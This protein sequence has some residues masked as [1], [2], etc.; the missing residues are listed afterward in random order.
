MFVKVHELN[1]RKVVAICDE[2]LIGK[3]FTDKNLQINV[4]ETFYHGEKK[5]DE[6]VLKLM[7]DSPNLNLVGMRTIKLA[8]EGNIIKKGDILKIKKV[9]H[10]QVIE[11]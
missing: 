10:A 8:L 2:D 9:P 4:S 11:Y 5:T 3:K 1:G 6:E 7:N